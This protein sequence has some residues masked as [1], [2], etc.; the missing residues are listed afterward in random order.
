MKTVDF[1]DYKVN[2][3]IAE[4]EQDKKFINSIYTL[5][6]NDE[7]VIKEK[8]MPY[9][10]LR[11]KLD[12]HK[13]LIT[14]ICSISFSF[15]GKELFFKLHKAAPIEHLRYEKDKNRKRYVFYNTAKFENRLTRDYQ[16]FSLDLPSSIGD[17][18]SNSSL[19]VLFNESMG[20]L[21]SVDKV[22]TREFIT[23]KQI[24][25]YIIEGNTL[26]VDFI[27]P[28]LI[29]TTESYSEIPANSRI[30]VNSLVQNNYLKLGKNMQ[31]LSN[32][33]GN[34]AILLQDIND[35]IRELYVGTIKYNQLTSSHIIQEYYYSALSIKNETITLYG[36]NI[37]PKGYFDLFFS[38]DTKAMKSIYKK[39]VSK[40][41]RFIEDSD[42]IK[43]VSP[44]NPEKIFAK[45]FI[46]DKNEILIFIYEC[47]LE[48]S[49]DNIVFIKN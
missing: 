43:V 22:G 7:L 19:N 24:S 40:D 27:V 26:K 32:N 9:I 10:Y 34:E 30:T 44:N 20:V 17:L 8:G 29:R 25:T 47:S 1:H 38:S 28:H 45:I 46:K 18:Y 31:I 11:I 35:D 13:L 37:Y 23:N 33:I 16:K 15:E 12:G 42:C 5:A 2:I 41:F 6:N 3:S 21:F 48:I 14:N 4:H 36:N 39:I 49:K